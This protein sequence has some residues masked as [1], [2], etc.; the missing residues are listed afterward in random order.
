MVSAIIRDDDNNLLMVKNIDGDSY[1]W[2]IPG[3]AVEEG[4]TLE[5]AVVREVKEETGFDVVVTGFNSLREKFFTKRHHHVLFATFFARVVGGEL[6][7]NDPDNDIA[8]VKW[9]DSPTA[10]ELMPFLFAALRLDSDFDMTSA[11]YVYEGT[12]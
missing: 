3:G 12:Q 8:E 9:V 6:G 4:E 7:I 10:Q 1:F 11:F 2:G 5:Q